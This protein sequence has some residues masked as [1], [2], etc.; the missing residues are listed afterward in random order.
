MHRYEQL[1]FAPIYY[2]H[3]WQ[4]L[5]CLISSIF[6]ISSRKE[7]EGQNALFCLDFPPILPLLLLQPD[8]PDHK[9]VN[10]FIRDGEFWPKN[11]GKH[12]Y[13]NLSFVCIVTIVT[14]FV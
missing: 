11:K 9:R 10:R 13:T 14:I 3:H 7:Q 2:C 1:N 6:S 8:S 5:N 12:I 4:I